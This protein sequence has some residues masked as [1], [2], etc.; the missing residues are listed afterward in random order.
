MRHCIGRKPLP[1]ACP[2]WCQRN[3]AVDVDKDG[4][5]IHTL[6]VSRQVNIIAVDDLETGE[7]TA[8]EITVKGYDVCSRA[9]ARLLALEIMDAADHL[10]DVTA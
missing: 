8:A 7:R 2:S 10:D 6:D 3:H 1:R 4:V 5:R 9:M